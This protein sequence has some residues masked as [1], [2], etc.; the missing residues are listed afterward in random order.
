MKLREYG[1]IL[2]KLSKQDGVES[3][4]VGDLAWHMVKLVEDWSADNLV[5][6]GDNAEWLTETYNDWVGSKTKEA[7]GQT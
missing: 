3:D 5:D 1:Y 6:D 2:W 7:D 4:A